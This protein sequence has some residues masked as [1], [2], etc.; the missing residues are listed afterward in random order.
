MEKKDEELY[1]LIK[2]YK[3]RK[4]GRIAKTYTREEE[5]AIYEAVA[6]IIDLKYDD[7]ISKEEVYELLCKKGNIYT[8]DF[9]Y[10]NKAGMCEQKSCNI[11]VNSIIRKITPTLMHELIHKLGFV[12][13]N[14]E[15][16]K[17]NNI[18]LE[19]GTELVTSELLK[20]K[21]C[22]I[23]ETNEI[24]T[25]TSDVQEVYFLST[26]LVNQINYL[27]GDNLLE[28]S[29]L[30]GENYF[31]PAIIEKFGNHNSKYIQ[32]QLEDIKEIEMEYKDNYSVS[33][34]ELLK[35]KISNLQD[36]ILD[37][38]FKKRYKSIEN[39][40]EAEDYLKD[41]IDFSFQ[42]V[43]FTDKNNP[44]P[45][46]NSFEEYFKSQKSELEEK[47][48]TKFDIEYK[49]IDWLT[50]YEYRVVDE[51]DDSEEKDIAHLA[52][53]LEAKF[54][55]IKI[56]DKVKKFFR[57]FRLEDGKNLKLLEKNTDNE[58]TNIGEQENLFNEESFEDNLKLDYDI[59][60]STG[61][62]ENN[63]LLDDEKERVERD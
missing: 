23:E 39:E 54:V 29:I 2:K 43:K 49:R 28:K 59:N 57:R 14:K 8:M 41:L 10:D 12:R 48:N 58:E 4:N 44:V 6:R 11:G 45:G 34:R 47:F 33:T 21:D 5:L 42:R 24:W 32:K 22:Y 26:A 9:C 52:N 27:V 60:L 20:T 1:N 50:K 63:S 46:D 19:A 40:T 25:K 13:E 15:F 18:Y 56:V 62:D 7:I 53:K 16:F 51:I 37:I 3:K 55:K 35:S 30:K 61:Y 17:M 36:N 38:S 31:E